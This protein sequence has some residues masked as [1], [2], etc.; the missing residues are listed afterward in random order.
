MSSLFS[1]YLK[2]REE[3]EESPVVGVTSRIKLQKKQGNN[4][5]LPFVIDN[6]THSNLARVVKAFVKSDRVNLGYTT[7]EKNKGEVE[8][9][10][11]KKTIYLTGGAVRDHLLGKTPRNYDLVTDATPSEI[12]MILSHAGFKEV[13]P[14]SDMHK[15]DRLASSV[16]KGKIFYASRWDK[17]GKEMEIVAIVNGQPFPISTLSSSPKSKN[18]TPDEAK[19]AGSIEEDASNRDFTINAMYIPLNNYDGSNNDLIDPF[20]GA[21]HLK[22]GEIKPIGDKLSDRMKEDPVTAFRLVNQFNRYGKGN[23]IPEKHLNAISSDD[24]FDSVDPQT[25]KDE[26]VK[27]L[28]NPDISAK[29]FL[30]TYKQSGLLNVLFPHVDFDDKDVPN[31]LRCDRWMVTAWILRNNRPEDVRD[32]LI[33]GGWNKHEANDVSYLVKM[34]QWGKGKFDTDRF[35]DMIQSHTGLTKSKIADWMSVVKMHGN[36]S[37]QFLNFNKDD[38]SPY[39]TNEIG[40]KTTNPMYIHVLG[41]EPVGDEFEPIKK[42]LMGQRWKDMI[43]RLL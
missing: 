20:G 18:F 30:R 41:R 14:Q 25:M 1:K 32:I 9:Q 8:P 19:M 24:A 2:L 36:E 7:I 35:Y 39:Q 13:K 42:M 40:G 33:A 11:K 43:G 29:K 16:G 37:Q 15:Y 34:Y 38:F 12:R 4:E 5:F 23:D 6:T 31:D 17:K 28:E 22:S 3:Q 27:G 21:N 10:L 26:F